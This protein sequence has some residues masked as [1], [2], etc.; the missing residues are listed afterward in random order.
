[1]SNK[2]KLIIASGLATAIIVAGL[3]IPTLAADTGTTGPVVTAR[4]DAPTELMD[5]AAAFLGIT[6][7]T[8]KGAFDQARATA[9]QNAPAADA[10]HTRVAAILGIDAATL[11]QAEKQAWEAAQ[12]SQPAPNII[13][14]EKR[15]G[16]PVDLNADV[17]KILDITEDAL[18]AAAEQARSEM[19]AARANQK[20]P[21]DTMLS[22][23]ATILGITT[24]KLSTALQQASRE[25]NAVYQEKELE[26][27]VLNNTITRDEAN[28]IKS[29]LTARPAA[30]D[31]VAGLS[32]MGGMWGTGGMTGMGERGG[33]PDSRMN[34]GRVGPGPRTGMPQEPPA[35]APES[36][37]PA[38]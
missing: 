13:S 1:M 11:T 25:I 23:V 9:Q 7:D 2:T 10:F 20:P 15:P 14:G 22:Q 30:L 18:Q 31:R 26:K 36:A 34:G 28:Q 24:D 16:R 12:A 21:E 3:A 27:A 4:T 37:T 35:E 19:K 38:T 32:V 6:G 5:K 29:W 17:A 33:R 8:L